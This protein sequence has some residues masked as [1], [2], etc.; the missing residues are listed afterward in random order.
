M[1]VYLYIPLYNPRT[2]NQKTLTIT[3]RER[4][5]LLKKGSLSDKL[6][7]DLIRRLIKKEKK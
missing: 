2:F 4:A 5:R 6:K 1:L 7:S 3:K